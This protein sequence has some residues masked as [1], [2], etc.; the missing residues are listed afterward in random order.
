MPINVTPIAGLPDHVNDVRIRTANFINTEILPRESELFVRRKGAAVT[1]AE[2][3][4]AKTLRE[5]IKAKVKSAGLWA[6]H[7]PQEYG[8]MGLDFL[9]HAYMNEILAYALG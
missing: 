4:H 9:A 2:L 6:P 8:G 1:E 7:L 3:A 5:E